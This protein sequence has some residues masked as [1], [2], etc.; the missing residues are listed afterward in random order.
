[1]SPGGGKW[2]RVGRERFLFEVR[3]VA[4]PLASYLAAAAALLGGCVWSAVLGASEEAAVAAARSAGN[5]R[6]TAAEGSARTGGEACGD[7]GG[8]G[9]HKRAVRYGPWTA[10]PAAAA[11]AAETPGA[12]ISASLLGV[13]AVAAE[14]EDS[15]GDGSRARTPAEGAGGRR[16]NGV[17]AGHGP[18]VVMTGGA[19]ERPPQAGGLLQAA[20]HNSIIRRVEMT[21]RRV[22]ASMSAASWGVFSGNAAASNSSARRRYEILPHSSPGVL[23]PC[24]LAGCHGNKQL[25]ADAFECGCDDTA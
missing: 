6:N 23:S 10:H 14:V 24:R 4:A 17:G 22:I 16:S 11:A 8:D 13:A 7:C 20:F 12:T 19:S 9:A 5:R 3:T 2:G 15:L 25:V 21:T 18:P 1:M